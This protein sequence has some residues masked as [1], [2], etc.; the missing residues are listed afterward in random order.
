MSE[1]L[2]YKSFVF[3]VCGHATGRENVND[4]KVVSKLTI[5]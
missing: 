1:N 5:S 2:K 4:L 3:K